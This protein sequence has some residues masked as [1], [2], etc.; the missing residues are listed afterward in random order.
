MA[1]GSAPVAGVSGC[2]EE[3][4]LGALTLGTR[5]FVHKCGV[6]R[7]VLAL[8]GGMDSAL[9]LAIAVDA[10][11]AD[12]VTAVLMPS[13]YSSRGSVDDAAALALAAGAEAAEKSGIVTDP[14]ADAPFAAKLSVTVYDFRTLAS[15]AETKD[16]ET[17]GKEAAR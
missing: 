9:V 1:E 11:G 16:D 10:L 7:A 6:S 14:V 4:V 17:K 8:S 12:N 13:P 5:D 2:W 3:G 15:D